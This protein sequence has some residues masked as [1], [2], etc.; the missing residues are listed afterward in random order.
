MAHILILSLQIPILKAMKPANSINKADKHES[1]N[2][3]VPSSLLKS[4]DFKM[5]RI[6]YLFLV[7]PFIIFSCESTPEAHFFT[8]T[9]DP[10]VGQDV[11]FTNDSH[12]ATKFEW[13]FGD[14]F[15]SSEANPVHYYTASGSFEA[16]L[17]A[18]SRSG[19]SDEASI[20]IDVKI[21]TLLEIEVVE[22]YDEYVVEGASVRLYPT[23]VDWEAETSIESEGFTDEDGL[24]VFSNLG[25]YVYY[26]DVWEQNHD[27]YDLAAEDVGFIRTSEIMPHK[28]NRFTAW[29]D[30]VEH[31]KSDGTRD[32]TMVI[33]KLERKSSDKSMIS[34]DTEDWKTLYDKSI[35]VK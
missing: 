3:Q 10:E 24:V 34:N 1:K 19:I 32:R 4:V 15:V 20:T 21:P 5:K 30:Y 35:K 9:L 11:L 26:V 23:L 33:K 8:D 2:M 13:D 18:F 6:I 14:G 25:P 12:N 17:T 31:T 28:I 22:W 29:V 27:N 16:V 7:L